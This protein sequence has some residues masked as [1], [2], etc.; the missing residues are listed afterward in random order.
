MP[1][2]EL[3]IFD[4]DGTLVDTATDVHLCLNLAL[5]EMNLP[6]ISLETAKKAIGPGPK[7]FV[8]YVLADRVDLAEEFVQIY[9]PF[10]M[11]HCADNAELYDGI[12]E[13][14]RELQANRIKMAV[15]TNKTHRA[16]EIVLRALA[17]D[18]CFDVVVA[19]DQVAQPKPAPDMLLHICERL[20]I[21]PKNALMLGDTDN[22]ILAANAAEIRS[23]L[24]LWGFSE[25]FEALKKIS[26]FSAEYPL[27]V[28]DIIESEIVQHV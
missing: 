26:T 10:Y 1:Q 27:Q 6:L 24:A 13:L 17:I 14:L 11:K 7:E 3:V 28:L 12:I 23:C 18:S 25:H 9:R 2:T 20:N 8:K 21:L 16:T 5:Q 4:L 22:D 15:A 19:R